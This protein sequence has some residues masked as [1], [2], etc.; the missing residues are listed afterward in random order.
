MVFFL[1]IGLII[2]AVAV[3]F[4]LQ[5]IIPVTVTFFTWQLSG[6]LAIVILVALLAG[7]L[8]TALVV[9]PGLL[10]AE[11]QLRALRKR[12]KKLE[13]DAMLTAAPVASAVVEPAAVPDANIVDL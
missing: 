3:I 4:V 1:I 2:G 13:D 12:N 9:L 5:N 8:I 6:S 11:W 7:M 10:S